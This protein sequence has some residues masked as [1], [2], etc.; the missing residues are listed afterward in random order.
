M[1]EDGNACPV[2]ASASARALGLSFKRINP[3][4]AVKPG[5]NSRASATPLPGIA[6]G[7]S[8]PAA[9]NGG[10]VHLNEVA[11]L[12][13]CPAGADTG[14]S[15]AGLTS[16]QL[17]VIRVPKASRRVQPETRPRGAAR[18][19]TVSP[20]ASCLRTA[21]MPYP[22]APV[23]AHRAATHGKTARPS[24]AGASPCHSSRLPFSVAQ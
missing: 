9:V 8:S 21:A 4:V 18:P 2:V 16:A 3:E 22:D 17:S 23:Q 13:S 10:T 5:P 7:F 11:D 14:V 15:F 24:T 12:A 19:E 1:L 6:A 20:A